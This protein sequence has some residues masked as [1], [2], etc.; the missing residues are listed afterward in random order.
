MTKHHIRDEI[1]HPA[2]FSFVA[3]WRKP[4]R[5]IVSVDCPEGSA[6]VFVGLECGHTS[7]CVTH[8]HYTIGENHSCH[9]CGIPIASELPE[10][11]GHYDAS[12]KIITMEVRK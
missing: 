5:K 7:N 10:F 8:F 4:L 2:R 11:K 9:D 1:P 6:T 3:C 12:G